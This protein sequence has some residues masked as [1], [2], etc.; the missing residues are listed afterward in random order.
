[1]KNKFIEKKELQKFGLFI[2]FG[3][4]IIFGILLPLI[5]GQLIKSWTLWIGLTSL[6]LSI[7]NPK[8]L[9]IP[10]KI[11]LQVSKILGWFNSKI[12][13]GSIFF[14]ILLPLAFFM[15]LFKYDPLRKNKSDETSFREN[16]TNKNDLNRI[17]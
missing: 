4:P 1:M 2:G 8:F 16:K 7:Y 6:F 9:N 3:F 15:R 10:Y 17:F 14:I 13:L 11:W 12:I 5:T